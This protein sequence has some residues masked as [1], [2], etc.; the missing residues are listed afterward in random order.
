MLHLNSAPSLEHIERRH[1][2]LSSADKFCLVASATS[3]VMASALV[4]CVVLAIPFGYRPTRDMGL[5]VAGLVV[6]AF[7]MGAASN[8]FRSRADALWR[9]H[10][11][12]RRSETA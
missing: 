8:L 9:K 4:V 2:R 7:V 5:S 3:A 11:S 10:F 12:R 1:R 6:L